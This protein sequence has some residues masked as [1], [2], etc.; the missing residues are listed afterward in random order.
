MQ[1]TTPFKLRDWLVP[2]IVIPAFLLLLVLIAS[3]YGS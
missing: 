2:P 1:E 3:V